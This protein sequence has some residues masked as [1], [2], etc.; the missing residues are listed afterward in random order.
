MPTFLSLR[1]NVRGAQ[2]WNPL[3]SSCPSGKTSSPWGRPVPGAPMFHRADLKKT[4]NINKLWMDNPAP[5]GRRFI[6][7]FIGSHLAQLVQEFAHR[8]KQTLISLN[9]L[10]V[11]LFAR[12]LIMCAQSIQADINKADRSINIVRPPYERTL[13]L[14]GTSPNI[15]RAFLKPRTFCFYFRC[16]LPFVFNQSPRTVDHKLDL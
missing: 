2:A 3:A 14:P 5:V 8:M 1:W 12:Y 16:C 9:T 4:T 7:L 15:E 10:C 6:P 13:V 11:L